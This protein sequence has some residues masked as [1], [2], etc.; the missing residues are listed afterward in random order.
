MTIALDH[1]KTNTHA[2]REEHVHEH[3]AS[4]DRE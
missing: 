1:L 3:E 4:D 2:G